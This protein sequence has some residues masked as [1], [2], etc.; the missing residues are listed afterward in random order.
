MIGYVHYYFWDL[1]WLD[2]SI[3]SVVFLVLVMRVYG[4][5]SAGTRGVFFFEGRLLGTLETWLRDFVTFLVSGPI[6]GC[7]R[8]VRIGGGGANDI[9]FIFLFIGAVRFLFV[10]VSV[11]DVYG[12]VHIHGFL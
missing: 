12:R 3:F 2:G 9:G 10:N 11:R 6:V 1:V 4:F 7:F 8:V 5:V